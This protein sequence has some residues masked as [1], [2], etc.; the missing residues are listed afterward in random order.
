MSG[1]SYFFNFKII[2]GF[3]NSDSNKFDYYEDDY[4]FG[5]HSDSDGM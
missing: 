4:L 5:V 3:H 2:T 1:R